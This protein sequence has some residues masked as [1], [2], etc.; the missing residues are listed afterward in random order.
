MGV[1][2]E[3]CRLLLKDGVR[4]EALGRLEGYLS[5]VRVQLPRWYDVLSKEAVQFGEFTLAVAGGLLNPSSMGSE[6]NGYGRLSNRSSLV[7]VDEAYYEKV[8]Q[9]TLRPVLHL[10]HT[11]FLSAPSREG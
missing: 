3:E 8:L 5:A 9:V 6:W 10:T 7:E 1:A 11:P 2:F 4:G